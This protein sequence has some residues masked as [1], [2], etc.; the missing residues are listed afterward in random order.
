MKPKN[1]DRLAWIQGRPLHTLVLATYPILALLAVNFS[2]VSLSAAVRPLAFSILA[3]VILILMFQWFVQDWKRAALI[4]SVILI[5]FY[6]YGHLYILMKGIDLNGFYLF[7]HRTL[8]PILVI[9]GLLILWWLLRASNRVSLATSV[10]NASCLYLLFL[11]CK[12]S[13]SNFKFFDP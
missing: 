9:A 3:S 12:L 4:S 7:R 2:E 10:L 1:K 11:S 6:S 5:L 13:G 8:I